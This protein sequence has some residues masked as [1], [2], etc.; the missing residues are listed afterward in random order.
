ML[1]LHFLIS[2]FQVKSWTPQCGCSGWEVSLFPPIPH[3]T[4]PK[5]RGKVLCKKREGRKEE[6]LTTICLWQVMFY[7]NLQCT[8]TAK[9]GRLCNLKAELV[10]HMR[11]HPRLLSAAL[12]DPRAPWISLHLLLSHIR[13]SSLHHLCRG[14][15]YS[16]ACIWSM[17]ILIQYTGARLYIAAV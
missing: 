6:Y 5:S 14:I 1:Q 8:Q 12:S 15:L 13:F 4:L 7:L 3:A 17:C 10:Q 9:P 11:K 16:L 2:L